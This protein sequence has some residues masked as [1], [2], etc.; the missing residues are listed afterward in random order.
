MRESIEIVV[1][2]DEGSPDPCSHWVYVVVESGAAIKVCDH[3]RLAS[4]EWFRDRHTPVTCILCA[5]AVP[6]ER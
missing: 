1:G 6:L 3:Q 5:A 4:W 2:R